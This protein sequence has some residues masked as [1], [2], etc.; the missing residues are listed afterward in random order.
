MKV[1]ILSPDDNLH[2][3][4]TY[5]KGS[6]YHRDGKSV[7]YTRFES[8][9][10]TSEVCTMDLETGEERVL[11][12]S[13]YFTYHSGSSPYFC[14]GGSSV[15]Y[16]DS[17]TSV[18]RHNLRS[19]K[20]K[21]FDGNI[22]VYSGMLDKHFIEIDSDFPIEEQGAMGIYIRKIDGTGRRCLATVDDL[23]D[24]NPQGHSIRGSKVLLRLGAEIRPDQQQIVLFLVTQQG[25]LIRDYYLCGM[26]GS[27]LDF[28]GRLGTHIMWHPDCRNIIA[29]VRPTGCSYFGH[30]RGQDTNWNYGVL[31]SYNTVTRRMRILSRRK[32][33]GGCHPSPSP[34]GKLAVLDSL[35]TDELQILLYDYEA[36][37]MKR[38]VREPRDLE[39]EQKSEDRL[40]G[41]TH[42][43]KHY[44]I[45]A[46][47]A[48]S[49]DSRRILYNSCT[50]GRVEL[51]QI[52]L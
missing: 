40:S 33:L 36:R 42:G 2:R 30:L 22:C 48:F 38:L 7:L 41:Y 49:H 6:P 45:N 44:D 21:R 19:G 4:H 3:V 27:D 1:S 23:L 29:F 11:G 5:F 16:Q 15:I 10:G 24:A 50:A 31:A 34:D 51:A 28:H 52:E 20:Q 12:E 8:L 25:T 13:S 18:V 14:D 43:Y 39:V 9:E 17:E 46:H 32:I 37:G 26:D 35:Q 47:P